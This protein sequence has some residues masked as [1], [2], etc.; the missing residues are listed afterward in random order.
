MRFPSGRRA[1]SVF[2]DDPRLGFFAQRERFANAL[3]QG[4]VLAPAKNLDQM[5]EVV[6]KS[7]V[8]GV[9]SVLYAVLIIIVIGAGAWTCIKALRSR[10]P[11]PTTETPFV[12]SKI[13]APAGLFPTA[14][15]RREFATA[16]AAHGG[17]GVEA[18]AGGGRP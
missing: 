2:S 11:L 15:E 13:S 17:E 12:E 7:T 8:D 16:G 18:G 10:E 6:T 14:E 1:R 5:R 3:D 9:L 4:E